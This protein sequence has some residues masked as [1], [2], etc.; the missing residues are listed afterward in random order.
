MEG[1]KDSELRREIFEMMQE[2]KPYAMYIKTVMGQVLVRILDP[3][4]I[5]P[6]EVMLVGDPATAKLE[7]ITVRVWTK[8][9]DR[10]LRTNNKPHFEKGYLVPYSKPEGFKEATLVNQIT[11]EEIE[12]ILSQP[13]YA[14]TNR[15]ALFTSSAPVRR[16]LL[17]A[18]KMN[19]PV[20]TINYIKNTLSNLEK[21]AETENVGR[22]EYTV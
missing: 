21:E 7:D 18:E 5:L 19:R 13:F 8:A 10:Y 2:D 20:K 16:F 9:E 12:H 4:R 1:L 15:L 3:M 11:D 14:L 17:A 6:A 22:V